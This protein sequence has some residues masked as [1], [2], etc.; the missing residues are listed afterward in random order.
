MRFSDA[1]LWRQNIHAYLAIDTK[2]KMRGTGL[3][4]IRSPEN[5]TCTER[6]SVHK[7]GTQQRLRVDLNRP[8]FQTNP[9]H[10]AYLQWTVSSNTN[11]L[12]NASETSRF[13]YN[14]ASVTSTQSIQRFAHRHRWIAL[15]HSSF[16]RRRWIRYF[17][18]RKLLLCNPRSC[19]QV[20]LH[21]QNC[22][23]LPWSGWWQKRVA[24]FKTH[25]CWLRWSVTPE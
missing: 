17:S 15:D 1:S 8:S 5:T 23:P 24:C 13:S 18:R 10:I 6:G 4:D 14:K 7:R 11:I 12:P 16:N 3:A 2:Q 25:A 9:K 19:G 21:H 22:Q 20:S